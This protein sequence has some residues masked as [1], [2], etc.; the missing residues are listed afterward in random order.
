M[1]SSKKLQISSRLLFVYNNNQDRKWRMSVLLFSSAVGRYMQ[2]LLKM[3][4]KL[5]LCE[6]DMLGMD[7]H[8]CN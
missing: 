5:A 6:W 4:L 2:I 7:S 1:K 8:V 3:K